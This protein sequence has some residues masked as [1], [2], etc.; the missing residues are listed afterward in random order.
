MSFTPP[1]Q[2][3]AE[4]VANI[5]QFEH[6]E[7]SQIL[8]TGA[9]GFLGTWLNDSLIAANLKYQLGMQISLLSRNATV[10]NNVKR[11]S[12]L[13]VL[14]H[15]LRIPLPVDLPEFNYVFHT[16][17]PSQPLTGG[18]DAQSVYEIA[19]VGTN[20]LLSH[21]S[22]QNTTPV[23][24]HTSSGAV[25]KIKLD[26]LES[27]LQKAYRT[28]KEEAEHMVV[29]SSHNGSVIGTNPRLY[30]FAGPGI[31]TDAHFVAGEFIKKAMKTEP[32]VIKGNPNTLRSYMYPTDLIRW[33]VTISKKPTLDTIR[34][35][36]P[37]AIT[38][39]ELAALVYSIVNFEDQIFYG[40]ETLR[41]TE[42]VPDLTDTLN[43]YP[44]KIDVST[45]ESFARWKNYLLEIS[46]QGGIVR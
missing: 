42:Y 12:G 8:I 44:F 3:I 10:P 29:S 33:L 6:F 36:S 1:K 34:V 19:T 15:D 43:R 25:D 22:K 26:N 23:F 46:N 20:N 4:I 11:L 5:E 14:K 38:I 35:G 41:A 7:N 45:R 39:A 16:A 17:T 24:L 2:D 30:T 32:L 31:N 28:G 9:T 40:D 18:N 37:N 21:L 27:E 13:H